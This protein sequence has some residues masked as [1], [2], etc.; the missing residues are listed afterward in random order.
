[1]QPQTENVD[2]LR[3]FIETCAGAPEP[4]IAAIPGECH[5]EMLELALVCD[6]RVASEA[7]TFRLDQVGHGAIP[8]RGGTQRLPRV[9]GATLAAR[10][11]LL[12]ETIGA[13]EALKHGLV[14]LVTH[15]PWEA[16]RGL[17]EVV[18]RQGPLAERYAKEA[19]NRGVEMPLEQALRFET[20]LTM[21]LQ[22]TADRA[23]G[24]AAFLE[25]RDPKFRGE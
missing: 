16:A 12:G 25:K 13:E 8:S 18:G 7:A 9:A 11:L 6:I 4:L 17:A 3:A 24:V 23:E 19:I 5:E 20:D 14:S 21:V 2:G 1:M 10:M 15:D 22:T